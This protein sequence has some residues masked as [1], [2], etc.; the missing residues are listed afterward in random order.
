MAALEP[1]EDVDG[2][3]KLLGRTFAWERLAQP[4]I[5]IP[6]G[7]PDEPLVLLEKGSQPWMIVLPEEVRDHQGPC[8]AITDQMIG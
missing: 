2:E 4:G 5:Q 8:R 6:L 3:S 7:P 1:H